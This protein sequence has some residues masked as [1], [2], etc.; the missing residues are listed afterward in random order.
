MQKLLENF[1]SDEI[2]LFVIEL[3]AEAK[4]LKQPIQGRVLVGLLTGIPFSK[5]EVLLA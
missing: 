2:R 4:R 5:G 1:D 3:E